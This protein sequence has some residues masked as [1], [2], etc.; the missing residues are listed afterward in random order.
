MMFAEFAR[1]V[2]RWGRLTIVDA[3]TLKYSV[4][5]DDPDTYTAPWTI[6]F[7]YRR[8]DNYTQEALER[9]REL[10]RQYY[11]NHGF[12]DAQV[13]SAVAEYNAERDRQGGQSPTEC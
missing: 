4:T 3:N 8:D 6:A 5:V 11:A 9:D 7:P 10:I 1:R 13:T 12:P 2:L